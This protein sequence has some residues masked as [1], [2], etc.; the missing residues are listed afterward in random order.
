[1]HHSPLSIQQLAAI[2]TSVSGSEPAVTN[3]TIAAVSAIAESFAALK[4]SMTASDLEQATAVAPQEATATTSTS[5]KALVS[6]S[7]RLQSQAIRKI[8]QAYSSSVE[9]SDTESSSENLSQNN[10]CYSQSVETVP[11][12]ASTYS[13]QHGEISSEGKRNEIYFYVSDSEN[14]SVEKAS[15]D[16]SF[17]TE[18]WPSSE[19]GMSLVPAS[20]NSHPL[21]SDTLSAWP[22]LNPSNSLAPAASDLLCPLLVSDASSAWSHAEPSSRSL[23]PAALGLSSPPLVSDA[24][25]AWSHAALSSRTVTAVTA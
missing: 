16:W 10:A 14:K 4:L 5:I 20:R 2:E 23:A 1:V 8:A 9:N 18:F 21:M 24:S 15:V 25:I 7:D 13:Q 19:T 17:L 12:P 3:G 6:N 22:H 11:V